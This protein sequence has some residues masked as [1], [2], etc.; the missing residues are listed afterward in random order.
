METELRKENPQGMRKC[1]F[2]AGPL[3]Q[4]LHHGC[5]TE[6]LQLSSCAHTY[7]LIH[8]LT[9]TLRAQALT[10]S[11]VQT[12]VRLHTYPCAHPHALTYVQSCSDEPW[13]GAVVCLQQCFMWMLHPFLDTRGWSD[14]TEVCPVD[15]E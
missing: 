8:M 9:H 12:Q 10:Y 13:A 1:S 2:S 7:T 4:G 14:T 11:H 15:A 6:S 3:G 5:R